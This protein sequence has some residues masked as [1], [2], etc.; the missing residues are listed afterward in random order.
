[1]VDNNSTA[2]TYQVDL[3][4]IDNQTVGDYTLVYTAID[5]SGNPAN[6]VN[7]VVGVRDYTAPVLSLL[8]DTVIME[9]NTAYNEPG[10]TV[11]DNYDVNISVQVT[12]SVDETK[13]GLYLL[14]YDAVDASGNKAN[15]KYRIVQVR[16]TKAPVIVLNGDKILTLCRW[17][18]Y[19]DPGY[20]VT[21][22]YDQNVEVEVESNLDN[23][24]EG[25]YSIRYT[26]RDKAGNV[27]IAVDRLIR[28][29]DCAT[30]TE[31]L[32]ASQ[33]TVY[34]N[35]S[36]GKITLHSTTPFGEEPAIRVVDALGKAMTFTTQTTQ[37]GI[38]IDI[39]TAATGIYFVQVQMNG[40]WTSHKVQIIR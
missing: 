16:D 11:S 2:I 4:V 21:D 12:G 26:A 5:S 38:E 29:I 37:E 27:A 39:Q 20:V 24:W 17:E 18:E 31:E 10:F 9:V 7:R 32:E 22:N 19:T 3:S 8:G 34:P 30:G 25:L 6:P 28:V 35:P 1:V 13:T 36:K 14:F 15:T 33:L 23:S 40:E